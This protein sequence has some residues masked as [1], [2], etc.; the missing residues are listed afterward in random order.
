MP[1]RSLP[2]PRWWHS[3]N[4]VSAC[5]VRLM[6]SNCVGRARGEFTKAVWSPSGKQVV[7]WQRMIQ[8]ENDTVAVLRLDDGAVQGFKPSSRGTFLG[9]PKFSRDETRLLLA[10]TEGVFSITPATGEIRPLNPAPMTI[11]ASLHSTSFSDDGARAAVGSN[12]VQVWD[13][14]MGRL[15][16]TL[17]APPGPLSLSSDGTRVITGGPDEFVKI[18]SVNDGSAITLA[19]HMAV[20]K[21]VAFSPDASLAA[22]SDGTQV[23]VWDVQQ[24]L[25]KKTLDGVGDL[26]FSAD[27]TSLAVSTPERLVRF[28]V[29][30]WTSATMPAPTDQRF[31]S[32]SGDLS[33]A[34][35]RDG[36]ITRITDAVVVLKASASTSPWALAFTPEGG[37][38]SVRAGG[39]GPRLELTR[40]SDG[41]FLEKGALGGSWSTR[42]NSSTWRQWSDFSEDG[43]RLAIGP[44]L[45][46]RPAGAR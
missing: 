14:S 21:S 5:F 42:A 43:S 1:W 28:R 40:V 31:D 18:W 38:V 29:A 32:L 27:G 37:L 26:Q 41:T 33:Q 22:S 10:H 15:V 6:E 4:P 9:T 20:V 34:Y 45:F 23:L 44:L 35:S 39:T 7:L 8:A 3:L 36:Q 13:L 25:L 11:G 17:A 19:G 46:C 2:I 30:D 12:D 24:G 16:R